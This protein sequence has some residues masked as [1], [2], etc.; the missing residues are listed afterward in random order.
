MSR[1]V[2]LIGYSGHA[3]VVADVLRSAGRTIAGYCDRERKV[4]NPFGLTYFGLEDGPEGKAQ[5]RGAD[6]FVAIGANRIRARVTERLLAE[7]FQLASAANAPSSEVAGLATV[8]SGALIAPRATVNALATIGQGAIINTAAVVEHECH[9]GDHVHLGPGAVLTGNVR[10]GTGA[11]I[12]AGAVVLPGIHIGEWA[13]I[14]AGAV[15]LR[16]VSPGCTVY[17]NPAKPKV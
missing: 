13:I 4:L 3:F 1:P 16:D 5:L 12:G 10:V 11:F 7:G 17:G 2:V 6:F 8:D 14:G 15:V 9:L